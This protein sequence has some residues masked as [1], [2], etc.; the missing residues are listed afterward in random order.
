[1]P[2]CKESLSSIYESLSMPFRPGQSAPES[3]AYWVR[4]YQHRLPQ[5]IQMKAGDV[6]PRCKKCGGRVTFEKADTKDKGR[7]QD[8]D[9]AA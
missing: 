7:V 5:L 3:G 9:L 8:R 4:H 2:T 1:M 6:F